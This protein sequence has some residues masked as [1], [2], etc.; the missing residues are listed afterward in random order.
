[1]KT[2]AEAVSYL[3]PDKICDQISDAI[4]DLHLDLDPTARVAVECAGGHG[5]V[6]LY[7]EVTSKVQVDYEPVVQKTYKILTGN[8]IEVFGHI[9][10][11][12][13]DIAKGVDK[14]GAGDQG[15]M[16]GYAT[17]DTKKGMPRDLQMAK[18]LL[19]PFK[20]D[21][22]SQVTYDWV[23]DTPTDIVLS[24][25]GKSKKEL[26][27]YIAEFTVSNPN[28]YFREVVK[29]YCN[30]TGAFEIGGFDA[31][32]GVTGRKIV[33]DQYGPSVPTGGGAFSGKDP[34][35][36]DRSGAYM[37]RWLALNLLHKYGEDYVVVSIAYVI[38]SKY[39]V[40]IEAI[41]DGVPFNRMDTFIRGYKIDMSVEGIIE[42]FDLRRPI[43]QDLA[44]NGHFGRAKLPWEKLI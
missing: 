32:S 11:Q 44:K 1:M 33:Q 18:D 34:T 23:K 28:Y 37:A 5:S 3:H 26:E 12:S 22:K 17:R 42:R 10:K 25:Q 38:G 24:V 15:I 39:P 29:K 16:V 36:V 6:T 41:V 19:I 13:P 30:N 8:D 20:A 43:Y 2:T 14:G 27:Q 35:K 21:A 7:G 31:D 9:T 4:V 40:M